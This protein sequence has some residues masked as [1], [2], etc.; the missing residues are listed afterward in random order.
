LC[1]TPIG[2]FTEEEGVEE[3]ELF[4]DLFGFVVELPFL[5][6]VDFEPFFLGFDVLKAKESSP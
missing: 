2:F 4:F 6:T 1:F 5:L 3:G